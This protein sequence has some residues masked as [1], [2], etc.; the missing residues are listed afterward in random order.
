MRK[1]MTTKAFLGSLVGSAGAAVRILMAAVRPC[2][3]LVDHERSSQHRRT[4]KRCL[5]ADRQAVRL[6]PPVAGSSGPT[7]LP[8]AAHHAPAPSPE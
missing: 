5:V 7:A 2:E 1:A 4:E 3:R 8:R 6:D